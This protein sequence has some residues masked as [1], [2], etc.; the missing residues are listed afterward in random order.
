MDW[1]ALHQSEAWQE[2]FRAPEIA[3]KK[4]AL[5]QQLVHAALDPETRGM[6]RGQIK[7]LE[8]LPV[9]VEGLARQQRSNEEVEPKVESA[10][11]KFGL[12][13]LIPTIY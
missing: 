7:M 6:I 12:K 2:F 11:R 4:A 10:P 3:S 9:M 1:I 8:A 13:S 5:Y